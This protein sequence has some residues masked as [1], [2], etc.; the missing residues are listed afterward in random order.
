[1]WRGLFRDVT[2]KE[3]FRILRTAAAA[4]MTHNVPR[5][6]ASLAFYALFSLAPL[7]ILG[8]AI[9]GL[10]FNRTT[11]EARLL[12]Q[13]QEI[14]G[15]VGAQSLKMVLD[16]T[17]E[18]KTGIVATAVAVVALLFGASGVFVELRDSLNT[19]WDAP[20]AG[21][22]W[23]G[24]IGQRLSSF[25]MVLAL[26]FLLLASLLV[27]TVLG[28]IERFF[29]N[30]V[31]IDAALAGQALNWVVSLLAA[32]IL[33]A[34]VF[35]FVPDVPIAWRDV[36]AGAIV[37]SI[38]FHAGRTLLSL[39]LSTAGVGSAYGAAG[40]LVVFV[41]WVYYSAQIF[42]FGAILTRVYADQRG[43]RRVRYTEGSPSKSPSR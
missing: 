27:S 6:G 3:T 39:Y 8:V 34:L 33:F 36:V 43:S 5:L 19:I 38:L 12:G 14:I 31:P 28:V 29:T 2:R 24:M 1:M 16:S 9:C 42:F 13:I 41:V 7:L 40:S 26:G 15:H 17:H 10:V 32:A 25:A 30:L 22:D 20:K 21:S 11:A 4:W 35:K 23:R 37:T 18:T